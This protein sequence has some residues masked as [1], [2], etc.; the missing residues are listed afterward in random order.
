[1]SLLDVQNYDFKTLNA[2]TTTLNEVGVYDDSI[3]VE[4]VSG[5]LEFDGTVII[6]DEVI[7]YDR[8]S[9]GP[10]VVITPGISSA[11]YLK[12]QQELE[13]IFLQLDGTKTVFDLRLLGNPV[14]PVSEDHLIVTIYGET[15]IPNVD[16]FLEGDKIRF[17][18]APRQRVGTDSEGSTKI[19]YLIG[20]SDSTI[21][22]LDD[23][24]Q[25]NT[26]FYSTKLN[27]QPYSIISEISAIIIRNGILQ[28][29]YIDFSIY[30]QEPKVIKQPSPP[31]TPPPPTIQRLSIPS[32]KARKNQQ[33][34]Q[35]LS[36]SSTNLVPKKLFS[37]WQN[38]I[39]NLEPQNTPQQNTQ[40]IIKAFSKS[41]LSLNTDQNFKPS[42]VIKSKI[43]S[44]TMSGFEADIDEEIIRLKLKNNTNKSKLASLVPPTNQFNQRISLESIPQ[45]PAEP[46][47]QQQQ[48]PKKKEP[49]PSQPIRKTQPNNQVSSVLTTSTTPVSPTSHLNTNN[50]VVDDSDLILIENLRSKFLNNNNKSNKIAHD[51]ERQHHKKDSSNTKKTT[52]NIKTTSSLNNNSNNNSNSNLTLNKNNSGKILI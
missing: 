12:R 28:K 23:N 15:L 24:T 36:N 21:R 18:V 38:L 14:T 29:P 4:N 6:D 16:Y 42:E 27:S 49:P 10:E 11:E 30:D 41:N 45:K 46:Q 26:K 34:Q 8:I 37:D 7:Y 40:P 19:I 31:P 43:G 50:T 33:Q 22:T 32:I 35:Q 2:T 51:N 1:M 3:Q 17:A 25:N 48:Q 39:Q 13:N 44:S 20:F 47:Q 52:L 9:K 5:F